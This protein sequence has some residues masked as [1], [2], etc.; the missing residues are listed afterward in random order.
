[1]IL[2]VTKTRRFAGVGATSLTLILILSATM[3]R[4]SA[5]KGGSLVGNTATGLKFTSAWKFN[6]VIY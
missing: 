3:G 2:Y 4:L 1:M 6:N 5:I